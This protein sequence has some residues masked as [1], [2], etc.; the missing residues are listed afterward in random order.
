MADTVGGVVDVL[1]GAPKEAQGRHDIR[2]VVPRTRKLLVIASSNWAKAIETNEKTSF[3][4]P[5]HGSN[6]ARATTLY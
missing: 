4:Q 1:G 3:F 2:A 6:P 5:R